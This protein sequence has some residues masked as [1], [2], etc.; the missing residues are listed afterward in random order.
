[1]DFYV[2]AADLSAQCTQADSLGSP[3]VERFRRNYQPGEILAKLHQVGSLV[4][5]GFLV[6]EAVQQIGV[7]WSTYY[8]WR[9][10]QKIAKPDKKAETVTDHSHAMQHLEEENTRLR[11]ALADLM[12]EKQE[13]RI[14]LLRRV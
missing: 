6:S 8:R 1:M 2:G 3:S 4:G 7:S 9:A 13:L 5:Q 14:S 11:W 12:L 10:S